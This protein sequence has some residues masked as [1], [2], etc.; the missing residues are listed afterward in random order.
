MSSSFSKG[1][2]LRLAWHRRDLR[3]A[4]NPL[5][6]PNANDCNKLTVNDSQNIISL[7][8]FDQGDFS[9]TPSVT[10]DPNWTVA[11][12]GPHAARYLRRAVVDLRRS[13]RS[14]GG[15]LLV[16]IGDP[17]L[18][19]PQVVKELRDVTEV[20]WNEDPGVYERNTSD[21]VRNELFFQQPLVRIT[22][23][24]STPL[25]HPDDLPRS[26]Y[27]WDR[28]A[29]PKQKHT[30]ASRK[31]NGDSLFQSI[32]AAHTL[33]D[34]STA[35]FKGVPRIMGDFRRAA[36]AAAI[37]RP[38]LSTPKHLTS[39]VGFIEA[40]N[41]PTLAELLDPLLRRKRDC[42]SVMGLPNDFVDSIVEAAFEAAAEDDE[43]ED[44][45]AADRE[46]MEYQIASDLTRFVQNGHAATAK[47]SLADVSDNN[48]SRLSTF[49]ALGIISPRTVHAITAEGGE[50]ARWLCSHLTMR[51]FFIYLC[52]ASGSR[53]YQQEGLP[54]NAKR[55]NIPWYSPAAPQKY[56]C[57]RRWAQGFT[58]LPLIDAGMRELCQTGY[59]S[60]RVRQNIASVLCRD[61]QIDWRAGAEVL[62]FLLRD[63]CVAANWGNWLY[64]SGV[65]P[66][67]KSRH[68]RSVSQALRY[69]PEA[70]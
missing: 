59:C 14:I 70:L 12:T 9:L 35:R 42:I 44:E 26:K 10:G 31:Q 46:T 4:D 22:T 49:L 24:A 16:R 38:P 29:H 65:G 28:L 66:D 18:I 3:L 13:L 50:G 43:I 62:Q 53:L 41:I 5:Y 7:Y 61:L 64:F 2:S 69:D 57:W 67:P 33:V 32:E 47:R 8:V 34:V 68:F 52:F 21:N 15:E 19:V 20:T 27:D 30:K 48:S 51:D 25:Y 6:H 60:N 63:H 17:R 1:R 40:G 54:V 45:D 56:D 55:K 23:V 58:G 37:L 39:P 36:M 11:R